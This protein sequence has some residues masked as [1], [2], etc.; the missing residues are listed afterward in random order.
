MYIIFH[1]NHKGSLGLIHIPH[2]SALC[3]MIFLVL[4]FTWPLVLP[5]MQT[6]SASKYTET[7]TQ[8]IYLQVY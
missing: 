6:T 4:I 5:I 7:F 1:Q 3:V 8:G 2:L